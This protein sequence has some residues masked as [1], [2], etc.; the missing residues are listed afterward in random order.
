M[1]SFRFIISFIKLIR[2]LIRIRRTDFRDFFFPFIPVGFTGTRFISPSLRAV[3]LI[4]FQPRTVLIDYISE[5][6][7]RAKA[8]TVVYIAEIVDEFLN[9]FGSTVRTKDIGSF[10]VITVRAV[11]Y[12]CPKDIIIYLMLVLIKILIQQI[13]L[14]EVLHSHVV[15]LVHLFQNAEHILHMLDHGQA[16]QKQLMVEYSF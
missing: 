3:I 10:L 9:V 13:Q 2:K 7:L 14:L 4:A 16:F 6:F 11:R 15:Q 8:R 1:L 12:I 5:K